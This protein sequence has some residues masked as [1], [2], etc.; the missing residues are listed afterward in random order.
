MSMIY[1]MTNV[2]VDEGSMHHSLRF[3]PLSRRIWQNAGAFCD[4]GSEH[5]RHPCFL[6]LN[7]LTCDSSFSLQ[8]RLYPP[9]ESSLALPSAPHFFKPSCFVAPHRSKEQGAS[10]ALTPGYHID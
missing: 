10:A 1:L 5:Q 7:N 8:V 6:A 4:A 3:R 2:E 9:S